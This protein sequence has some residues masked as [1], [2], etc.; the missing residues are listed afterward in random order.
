M[1]RLFGP[2]RQLCAFFP[3]DSPSSV[4]GADFDLKTLGPLRS[5]DWIGGWSVA[6]EEDAY[7]ELDGQ[8]MGWDTNADA[9]AIARFMLSENTGHAPDLHTKTGWPLRR[10]N[11]AFRCLL[12]IFPDGRTREV[13]SEYV[14]LG[15]VFDGEDRAKLRRLVAKAEQSG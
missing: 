1:I 13:Q 11:P 4:E 5:R 2:R 12:P 8:M 6:L 14:V 7:A 3:E 15:V 10:F 9:I